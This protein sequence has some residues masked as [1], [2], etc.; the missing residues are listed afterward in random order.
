MYSTSEAAKMKKQN[1]DPNSL[2]LKNNTISKETSQ[3][4]SE[5]TSLLG[6]FPKRKRTLVKRKK[7]CAIFASLDRQASINDECVILPPKTN[8]KEPK[9]QRGGPKK[10]SILTREERIDQGVD[11][12]KQNSPDRSGPEEVNARP[13]LRPL[14]PLLPQPPE[15]LPWRAKSPPFMYG[16]NYKGKEVVDDETDNVFDDESI[17]SEGNEFTWDVD[18]ARNN[19]GTTR[20]SCSSLWI[21]GS[22]TALLQS[23]QP[24]PRDDTGVRI[25]EPA[26]SLLTWD[27]PHE[28][29]K[30]QMQQPLQPLPKGGQYQLPSADPDPSGFRLQNCAES[31][32]G[33][34][35]FLKREPPVVGLHTAMM[36]IAQNPHCHDVLKALMNATQSP[37][38]SAPRT[39]ITTTPIHNH[40]LLSPPPAFTASAHEEPDLSL[41]S[42]RRSPTLNPNLLFQSSWA[43]QPIPVC[44]DRHIPE[45]SRA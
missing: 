18:G 45:S 23:Q 13:Q 38:P 20:K 33:K 26:T 10:T 17:S 8:E 25:Q 24:P 11:Q 14:S 5:T 30:V 22:A 3:G 41:A 28:F 35:F 44:P 6:L 29:I 4:N 21:M 34:E 42:G 16:T 2:L 1:G 39:I 40:Q 31:L 27:A 12:S 43:E 9:R 15:P 7:L 36:V 32:Y 19:L 37:S